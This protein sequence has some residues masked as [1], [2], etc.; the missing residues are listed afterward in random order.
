MRQSVA[1]RYAKGLFSVGVKDGRYRE[2][3]GELDEILSILKR[4]PKL[5][6]ALTLPLLEAEKRKEILG[7]LTAT[8]GLSVAPVA[9]LTLLLER[10]RMHYLPLIRSAYEEMADDKEG[11]VKGVGYSAY[12]LSDVVKGRIEEALGEKLRKK[13]LLDVR[14][15]KDLIGGIK[16]VIGGVRIDGTVKRQLEI[17]NERIMKE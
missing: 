7:D 13:V 17:L 2:Y 12:P 9:L 14:Q 4:E 6:K 3:L 16:V 15:D 10:N 5:D 11:V 1:R 8:L